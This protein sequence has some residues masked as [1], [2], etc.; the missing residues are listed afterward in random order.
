MS[1]IERNY[2]ESS[3][4]QHLCLGKHTSV[5]RGA[6]A[7]WP[8]VNKWSL[9]FFAQSYPNIPIVTKIFGQEGIK[10]KNMSMGQYASIIGK[11]KIS[12]DEKKNRSIP[13]CHDVPIFL[14]EKALLND[15]G[16]FP[17]E[18]LPDWYAKNWSRYAQFFVS[19]KGNVTPLHFDTLLTHNLF[20]QIKGEKVFTIIHP[21]D[22]RYCYRK[23]W[24]WFDVDPDN[25]DYDKFPDFKH[26]KVEHIT[27]RSGDIFYMPPGTLHQVRSLDDG[28]SFNVDFH[29]LNSVFQSF[30]G[31]FKGMPLVN[32]RY[33]SQVFK[34]LSLGDGN[35]QC[36]ER[37]KSYLNYIS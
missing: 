25:P 10:S 6:V 16:W 24:R 22:G 21:R 7:D 37:Y 8:A 5:F 31:C 9:D 3:E 26:A 19:N 18:V 17:S 23:G 20:F 33:N 35:D 29:T 15:I 27:V 2:F 30:L 12:Q 11:L 34:A 13:Y 4:F 1:I 28:I 14:L 36:F 32:L